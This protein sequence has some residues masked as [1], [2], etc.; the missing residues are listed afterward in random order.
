MSWGDKILVSGQAAFCLHRFYFILFSWWNTS[1]LYLRVMLTYSQRIHLERKRCSYANEWK[2]QGADWFERNILQFVKPGIAT[3]YF[4][5]SLTYKKKS[6]VDK[7]LKY[8]LKQN[9]FQVLFVTN[10]HWKDSDLISTI[11][12]SLWYVS[13]AFPGVVIVA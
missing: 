11:S 8:E 7:V 13:T 6:N 3:S 1:I 2:R 12:H 9:E 10:T 4:F 5:T